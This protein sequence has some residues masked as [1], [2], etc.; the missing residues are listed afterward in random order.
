[1]LL[2]RRRNFVKKRKRSSSGKSRK[3]RLSDLADAGCTVT[4]KWS[5]LNNTVGFAQV[6]IPVKKYDKIAKAFAKTVKDKYAKKLLLQRLAPLGVDDDCGGSCSDG[7]GCAWI[8][9]QEN[10]AKLYVCD[11]W[12]NA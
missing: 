5:L 4:Q 1:M 11:C 12:Y 3:P 10:G 9:L 6:W 7:A 2:G 8:L